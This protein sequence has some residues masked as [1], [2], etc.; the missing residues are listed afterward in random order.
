MPINNLSIPATHSIKENAPQQKTANSSPSALSGM[1][2]AFCRN[3][4][5][6]RTADCSV[7]KAGFSTDSA[8]CFFVF[9]HLWPY[10]PVTGREAT[11]FMKY[12]K[13]NPLAEFRKEESVYG[14]S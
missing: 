10:L 11:A 9:P 14:I 1:R 2:N 4:L 6:K 5:F 7:F 13:G 12:H 3:A 8:V